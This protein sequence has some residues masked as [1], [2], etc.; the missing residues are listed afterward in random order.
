VQRGRHAGIQL[1]QRIVVVGTDFGHE[2]SQFEFKLECVV[3]G[4]CCQDRRPSSLVVQP[5]NSLQII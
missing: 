5:L 3:L 4:C 2:P 1:G